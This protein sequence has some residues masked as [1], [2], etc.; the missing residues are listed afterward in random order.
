MVWDC[1]WAKF[2]CKQ[3]SYGPL[4]MSECVFPQYLQSKWMNF[5]KILYIYIDIYK[6]HVICNAHYFWSIFD[7]VPGP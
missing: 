4:L 3:R 1:K 6:I 7:R 5:D 2:V